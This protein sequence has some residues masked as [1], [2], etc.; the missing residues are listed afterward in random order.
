VLEPIIKEHPGPPTKLI[1]L[2][3]AECHRTFYLERFNYNQRAKNS[4][5]GL[6]CS[7][8]CATVNHNK[9]DEMRQRITQTQTGVSVPSRGKIGRK[10]SEETREKIRLS[11]L[12]K[13]A[14]PIDY[15]IVL[16]ELAF[17]KKTKFAVTQ[18]LIPDAIFIED[19]KLVALELQKERWLC[20]VRRKMQAY[21]NRTDYDK[22]IIVWYSCSGERLK[23]WQKVGRGEWKEISS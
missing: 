2:K 7:T 22:V 5:R 16:R 14:S 19:G 6:F 10:F 8:K 13:P 1:T 3:C 11:K 17:R 18:G 15:A 4:K 20:G 21:N 23:E 9:S 12:G